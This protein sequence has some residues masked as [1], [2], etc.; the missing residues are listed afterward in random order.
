MIVVLKKVG[1]KPTLHEVNKNT[2][3]ESLR[4]LGHP[5]RTG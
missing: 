4:H 5:R 2:L 1:E 3:L